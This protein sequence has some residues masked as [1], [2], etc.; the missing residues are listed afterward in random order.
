MNIGEIKEELG[1]TALHFGFSEDKAGTVSEEWLSHWE[2]S[3]RAS[4]SIH[5]D[6]L[7]TIQ[8]DP[9]INTLAIQEELGIIAA[10][11]GEAYDRYRIVKFKEPFATL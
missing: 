3:K 9:S 7:K 1:M 6:T 5:L 4:V 8:D 2:N 11:S 10:E